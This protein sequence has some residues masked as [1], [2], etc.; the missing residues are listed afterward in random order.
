MKN[1]PEEDDSMDVSMDVWTRLAR[2]SGA[3][4]AELGVRPEDSGWI[5]EH[6]ESIASLAGRARPKRRGYLSL[7]RFAR[8][9]ARKAR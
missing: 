1:G 8:K 7:F 3:V 9:A 6:A 2:E 5:R 4:L